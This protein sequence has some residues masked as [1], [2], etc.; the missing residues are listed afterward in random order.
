MSPS[1]CWEIQLRNSSEYSLLVAPFHFLS[2]QLALFSIPL[3]PPLVPNRPCQIPKTKGG[4]IKLQR[5]IHLQA[6]RTGQY[7]EKTPR[8]DW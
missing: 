3:R 5:I 1:R 2:L 4:I 6:E 7:P 8:S